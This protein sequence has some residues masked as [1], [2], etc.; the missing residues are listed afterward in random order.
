MKI[1]KAR[2]INIIKLKNTNYLCQIVNS[3]SNIN[4]ID[5]Y[6]RIIAKI[7]SVNKFGPVF[8]SFEIRINK[9][10]LIIPY[11]KQ[12]ILG[13]VVIEKKNSINITYDFKIQDDKKIILKED[14]W[15]I[16]SIQIV[17]SN[18]KQGL[19]TALV[20]YIIEEKN[21]NTL[22]YPIVSTMIEEEG[23]RLFK[24]FGKIYRA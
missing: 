15:A 19:G 7:S 11:D 5:Y 22:I 12:N 2:S 4:T 13:A 3:K 17:K 1:S 6:R 20:K 16:R 14:L 9:V 10:E 18:Q 23:K 8:D 21:N 24:K